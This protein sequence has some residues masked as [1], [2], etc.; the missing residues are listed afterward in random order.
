[1][2]KGRKEGQ[3]SEEPFFAESAACEWYDN[4][5]SGC[6]RLG[7]RR[8]MRGETIKDAIVIIASDEV[9]GVGME[10]AHIAGER[11][12]CGGEYN[13]ETQQFLQLGG[14]KLYD[15]IDVICKKCSKKRS[16]FFDISSFYGKM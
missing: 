16:F 14:G 12:S 2:V 6:G 11:C 8:V 7:R 10:Y 4:N 13:V 5:G 15:K 3:N 1:M 9:T